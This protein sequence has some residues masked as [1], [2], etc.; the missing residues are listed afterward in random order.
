MKHSNEAAERLRQR[1]MIHHMHCDSVRICEEGEN[2]LL[3][4][5]RPFS[6][7]RKTDTGHEFS[8]WSVITEEAIPLLSL[9]GELLSLTEA[10]AHE[11]AL[12]RLEA[13]I[14]DRQSI[15]R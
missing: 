10:L 13:D 6:E 3:I 9:T 7:R 2:L 5:S 15:E 8:Y 4:R 12:N 1:L 14:E 11:E